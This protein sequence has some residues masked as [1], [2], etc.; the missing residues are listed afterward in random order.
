M[1][2][3]AEIVLTRPY[4]RFARNNYAH[5]SEIARNDFRM[6]QFSSDC[7]LFL[8]HVIQPYYEDIL[9]ANIERI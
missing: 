3:I 7:G 9:S 1:E 2:E 8:A 4:F 5:F 6:F